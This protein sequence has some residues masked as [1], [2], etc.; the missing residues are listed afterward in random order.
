[1]SII[2]QFT[3]EYSFLSNF[4][5]SVVKL[6]GATYPTVEHAYQAAKTY[7]T[8]AREAIRLCKTPSQAKRLGR[9]IPI[10]PDWENQRLG[11][12]SMLLIDKF[13][14][15]TLK[16]KLIDTGD[17]TLIEGN[18]WHDNYWGSCSCIRCPSRGNNNLGLLLMNMR[19]AA[20]AGN[21]NIVPLR[22][23]ILQG[24]TL[25]TPTTTIH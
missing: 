14:D 23:R 5:P 25:A 16:Q 9:A 11:I 4:Y 6:D 12:M 20:R 22:D 2:D 24:N 17:N 10:M 13:S 7:D 8:G 15:P 21:A 1:M 18:Y 19:D 3:D